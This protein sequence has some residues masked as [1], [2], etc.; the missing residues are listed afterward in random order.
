MAAMKRPGSSGS[1][2]AMTSSFSA[3]IVATSWLTRMD[4]CGISAAAA[5]TTGPA[6]TAGTVGSAIGSPTKGTV[7]AAGVEAARQNA[8]AIT[9]NRTLTLIGPPLSTSCVGDG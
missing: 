5:A 4:D 1:F 8:A 2:A 9:R 6:G 7:W 3:D